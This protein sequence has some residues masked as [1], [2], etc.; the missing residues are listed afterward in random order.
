MN[1][2]RKFWNILMGIKV[3]MEED[4]RFLEEYYKLRSRYDT[5]T[6]TEKEI[7]AL[8]CNKK[9]KELNNH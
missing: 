8:P 2:F 3:E 5:R 4:K 6:M 7:W 9:L 1:S